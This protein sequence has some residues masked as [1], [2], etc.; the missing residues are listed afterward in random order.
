MGWIVRFLS[1]P[2]VS[3]FTTGAAI[4]IGLSQIRYWMGVQLAR[5]DRL[6]A[7]LRAIYDNLAHIHWPTAVMG[8]IALAF[9]LTMKH[10]GKTVKAL[11]YLRVLGPLAAVV[12]G[13]LFVWLT[14]A[15]I[16]VIGH[17]PTG[18]PGFAPSWKHL[19]YV[20]RLTMPALIIVGVG[21][22]ESI[23]IAKA[24]AVRHNYDLD[25]NQELVG[26][27]LANV[28]GSMFSAYPAYGSFTRSSVNNDTGAR[29]PMAGVFSGLL[30][31]LVIKFLTPLLWY[32]PMNILAS[33][34]MSS[35]IGLLDYPEALFLLKVDRKVRRR[36]AA[37]VLCLASCHWGGYAHEQKPRV[38]SPSTVGLCHLVTTP[39]S[40]DVLSASK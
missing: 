1:H 11:K 8:V 23:S 18:L 36:G 22:I 4:I 33:I 9:L 38:G 26:L 30:V 34:V 16:P 24:L 40:N 15:N 7:I 14:E 29:T 28:I 3:G 12:A 35:V 6:P 20:Q 5:S 25:P 37:F 32:L 19:D 2:V 17:I 10:L 13:T 39:V 27:G 31:V 21:C